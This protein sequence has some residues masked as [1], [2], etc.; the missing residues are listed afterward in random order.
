MYKA[1]VPFSRGQNNVLFVIL[2]T[3]GL[4]YRDLWLSYLVVLATGGCICM[5]WKFSGNQFQK[6]LHMYNDNFKSFLQ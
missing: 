6:L 4:D 1:C 5:L 2:A 3:T